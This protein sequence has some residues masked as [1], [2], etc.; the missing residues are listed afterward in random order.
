[1]SDWGNLTDEEFREAGLLWAVNTFIL[2]PIGLALGVQIDSPGPMVVLALTEPETIV[3]GK[4]DLD[5]EPGGC[6]P[7]E[8]FLHYV[9]MRISE[10]PTEMEQEIATRRIRAL[11]PGFGISPLKTDATS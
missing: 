5:K 2:W 3:E 1:M 7:R 6:H 9:E 11:V 10:M 8:R 4:I